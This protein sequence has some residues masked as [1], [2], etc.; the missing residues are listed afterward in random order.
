MKIKNIRIKNFK[1]IY[2]EQYFDFETLDGLIKLSGVIGTGKT[3]VGEAILWGLYGKLKDHKKPYNWNR[4]ENKRLY[5][6]FIQF[7][8]NNF[9]FEI[10]EECKITELNEKEKYWISFY[11][12][13]PN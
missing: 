3:T 13:Y 12:T 4:E 11:N 9:T 10:I 2:G 8:L 1:S 5:Q 7:G 6:A